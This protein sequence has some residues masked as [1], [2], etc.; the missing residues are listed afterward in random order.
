M[1]LLKVKNLKFSYDKK[2]YLFENVNF[3]LEEGEVLSIL[4]PNGS[5][6]TTLLKLI[7]GMVNGEGSI[8]ISNQDIKNIS[9]RDFWKK[10]SFVPQQRN[11]SN[12]LVVFDSVMIGRS[13][14]IGPFAIPS[15]DDIEMCNK[16]IDEIGISHL[17][18]R[19]SNTLSGGEL[20]LVLIA[21]ALVSNPK[22]LILD[23]PESGLDFKNQL[24]ILNIIDKLKKQKITSIFNTH[25][26]KH[27]LQKSDKTIMLGSKNVL[28]GKT[29]DIINEKNI[30]ISFG[31][32][33]VINE[34]R[35]GEEVI[36][37][38]VPISVI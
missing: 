30:E 20:Q 26:P 1:S 36:K 24:V 32:K 27:A 37:N 3:T 17:K 11:V 14:F 2:K 29:E 22:I 28:Y 35:I 4:G 13:S 38:V 18:N 25:Y 15:K 21:R 12:D 19:L 34:I 8:Y 16:I 33:A 6:K 5:G 31:I 23:E 9:V 10:V 7:M